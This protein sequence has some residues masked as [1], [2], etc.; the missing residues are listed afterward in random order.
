MFQP[1]L[2]KKVWPKNNQTPRSST[3]IIGYWGKKSGEA[4]QIHTLTLQEVEAILYPTITVCSTAYLLAYASMTARLGL[5]QKYAR[6]RWGIS[7]DL[8]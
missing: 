8:L 6:F 7:P 5:P 1:I 3:T 2:R 4:G